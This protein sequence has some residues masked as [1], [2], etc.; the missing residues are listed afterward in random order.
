MKHL[1]ALILLLNYYNAS[2]QTKTPKDFGFTHIIFT[3][4]SDTVD[5]LVKSNEGEENLKK[6]LF[7]FCQGSQPKPLIIYDDKGTYGVFPFKPDSIIKK[8]HLVIIGK[9]YIP[10]IAEAKTLGRDFNYSDSTGKEPK[11]YSDRNLLSYYTDRNIEV[12][13]YLQKQKWASSKHLIVAGHSEGSTVA[14]KMA[15]QYP[16]ITHLIFSNGNPL[17]RIMSIIQKSRAIETDSAKYGEEDLKWWQSVVENKTSIDATQGNSDKTTFEFSIPPVE[18]LN[19]LNIPILVSYGTKDWS[20]PFNDFLQ[21]DVIRRGKQNFTFN[22]Y[23]GMEHNF[24]KLKADGRPDYEISN[25][26][27][28][29][30]DWLKWLNEN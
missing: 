2:A 5:I 11:E 1:I 29:V 18:Y 4:K 6:P 13:K 12:I 10:L 30:N 19:K 26:N 20:T 27:H 9:P 17:G 7:I 24:F 21:V 23:T 28:V 25:W 16:K 22:A 14:A 3:Y 8:Y 15:T